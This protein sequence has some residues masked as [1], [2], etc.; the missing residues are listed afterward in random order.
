M[1]DRRAGVISFGFLA[2]VEWRYMR[3]SLLQKIAQVFI[4]NCAPLVC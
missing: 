3:A 1:H 4:V 2:R